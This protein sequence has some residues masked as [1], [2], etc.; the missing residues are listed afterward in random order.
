MSNLTFDSNARWPKD[1][2]GETPCAKGHGAS[3]GH[4]DGGRVAGGGLDIAQYVKRQVS[5]DMSMLHLIK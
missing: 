3:E 1:M 4:G 5:Q 2:E